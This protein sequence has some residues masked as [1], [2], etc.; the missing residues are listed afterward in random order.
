LRRKRE[1]EKKSIP[2][3]IIG[4]SSPTKVPPTLA[5]NTPAVGEKNGRECGET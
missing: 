2:D 3:P 1:D 5:Y 4:W